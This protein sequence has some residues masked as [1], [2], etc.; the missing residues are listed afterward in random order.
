MPRRSTKEEAA[1]HMQRFFAET[2]ARLSSE[3][4]KT[5]QPKRR[6]EMFNQS[7]A[8]DKLERQFYNWN[9]GLEDNAA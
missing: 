1:A 2:R 5:M 9:N 4:L 6:T 8:L 3:I 7:V